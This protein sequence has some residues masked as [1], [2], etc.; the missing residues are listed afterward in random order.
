MMYNPGYWTD[1]VD[2]YGDGTS[3]PIGVCPNCDTAIPESNL[4]IR[5]ETE[6]GSVRL[7][8]ECLNCEI[9]VHPEPKRIQQ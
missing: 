6:D 8:A 9:P 2:K 7:F 4:L 1:M 3:E 5:Y